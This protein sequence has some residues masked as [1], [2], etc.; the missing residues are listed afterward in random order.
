[1]DSESPEKDNQSYEENKSSSSKS[2]KL[3]SRGPGSEYSAGKSAGSARPRLGPTEKAEVK[4]E[5]KWVESDL[6]KLRNRVK[7]L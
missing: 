7:M 2:K 5:K 3:K 1:M 4:I 6:Q